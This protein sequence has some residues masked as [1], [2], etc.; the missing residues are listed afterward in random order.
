MQIKN[1]SNSDSLFTT[2]FIFYDQRRL[3][4]NEVEQI[5]KAETK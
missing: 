4:G 3:G 5:K 2:H 1:K